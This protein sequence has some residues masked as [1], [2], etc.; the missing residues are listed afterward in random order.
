MTRLS[1]LEAETALRA[2][3]AGGKTTSNKMDTALEGIHRATLEGYLVRRE[4]PA[5]QW[6][7][8][9]HRISAHAEIAP[10]C[11]ALDVLHVAAA[12][13]LKADGFVTFDA[14]QKKLAAFEGLTVGPS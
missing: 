11:R 7:P 8:Q 3:V 12:V 10:V 9:A 14:D 5:K 4:V 6:F 13:V 2:A 1:V